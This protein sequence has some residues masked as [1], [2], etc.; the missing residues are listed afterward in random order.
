MRK[1]E[2]I[3]WT[4]HMTYEFVQ[5]LTGLCPEASALMRTT[6]DTLSFPFL[7]TFIYDGTYKDPAA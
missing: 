2:M 1:M 5:N 6:L 4:H 3:A 7:F